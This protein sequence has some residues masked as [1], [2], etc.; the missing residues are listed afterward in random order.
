MAKP[1]RIVILEGFFYH[2][3]LTKACVLNKKGVQQKPHT[4][5]CTTL[6]AKRI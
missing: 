5:K 1:T 3:A 4:E 2:V 6:A